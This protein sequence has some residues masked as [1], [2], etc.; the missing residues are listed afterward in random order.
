MIV[1]DNPAEFPNNAE[2]Q[3]I[4]EPYVMATVICPDEYIGALMDLCQKKEEG[5]SLI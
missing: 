4:W 2:I 5:S 1:I 3:E